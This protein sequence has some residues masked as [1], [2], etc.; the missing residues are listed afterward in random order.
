[1]AYTS[2]QKC[3]DIVNQLMDSLFEFIGYIIDRIKF[4]FYVLAYYTI[5][6]F[7]IWVSLIFGLFLLSYGVILIISGIIDN[8]GTWT[9][10]LLGNNLL[11]IFKGINPVIL[12]LLA[13]GFVIAGILL[14]RVIAERREDFV[15]KFTLYP[16]N[17]FKEVTNNE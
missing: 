15:F 2:I 8:T 6:W 11:F 13:L 14:L 17:K 12:I 1:M 16:Q 5:N 3:L 10:F 4:V 9:I 7:L